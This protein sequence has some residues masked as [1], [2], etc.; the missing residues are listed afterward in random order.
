M[1]ATCPASMPRGK[2]RCPAIWAARWEAM[3]GNWNE[4]NGDDCSIFV[5]D[6]YEIGSTKRLE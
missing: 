2:V 3:M 1:M 6:M 5:F 4:R